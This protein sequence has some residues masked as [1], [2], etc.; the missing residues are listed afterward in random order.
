MSKTS[1]TNIQRRTH[2]PHQYKHANI[3]M[4]LKLDGNR[5]DISNKFTS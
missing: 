3:A 1:Y 2:F 5:E 4:T